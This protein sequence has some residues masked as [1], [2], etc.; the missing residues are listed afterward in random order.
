MMMDLI[1]EHKYACKGCGYQ[2]RALASDP[3]DRECPSCYVPPERP[4][5]TTEDAETLEAALEAIMHAG[6]FLEDYTK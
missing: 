4:A 6:Y 5:L 1:T 3:I 2:M